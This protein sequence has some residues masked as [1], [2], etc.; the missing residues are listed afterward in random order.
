MNDMDI[1][2]LNFDTNSVELIT[3]DES[4]IYDI[5][6]LLYRLGYKNFKFMIGENIKL[7][8]KRG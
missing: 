6:E 3:Y 7:I 2:I 5:Y 4:D 8:D 1:V